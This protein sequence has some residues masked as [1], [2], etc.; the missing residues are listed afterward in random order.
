MS[1]DTTHFYRICKGGYGLAKR[2]IYATL[3]I[4]Y[5]EGYMEEITWDNNTTVQT[6]E[7]STEEANT[8]SMPEKRDDVA[9]YTYVSITAILA[10]ALGVNLLY[11]C[12]NH[13]VKNT[14]PDI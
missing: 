5:V 12:F 8:T 13:D 10:L 11:R 6:F 4:I 9:Y 14:T 1:D 3:Y 2:D 7:Y